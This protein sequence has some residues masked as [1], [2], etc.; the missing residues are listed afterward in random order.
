[1][2]L[3]FKDTIVLQK[4]SN[5]HRVCLPG[6]LWGRTTTSTPISFTHSMKNCCTNL[7]QVYS[8][9]GVG[10]QSPKETC[11][12]AGMWGKP[13]K[14]TMTRGG[15]LINKQNELAGDRDKRKSVFDVFS[16]II[17]ACLSPSNTLCSLF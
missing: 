9:G 4:A 16:T 8:K 10:R 6:E 11:A 15:F 13:A 1:M 7:P 2:N 12:N 14:A 3:M 5:V 17:D